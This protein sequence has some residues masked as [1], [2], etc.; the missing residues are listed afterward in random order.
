MGNRNYDPNVARSGSGWTFPEVGVF[1]GDYEL[2]ASLVDDTPPEGESSNDTIA[3]ATPTGVTA[4]NPTV[5]FNGEIFG[6]FFDPDLSLRTD[7]S[8]DVDIY[9]VELDA[10]DFLQIDIDASQIGSEVDTILRVFDAEGNGLAK[11][12]DDFAPEELFNADVGVDSYIEFTAETAGT[13][14]IGVSS[15]AN[16]PFDDFD[17]DFY[18]PNV[19]GSGSGNNFGEYEL[20]L[21]LNQPISFNGEPTVVEPPDGSGPSVSFTATPL[22]LTTDAVFL[23][24]ALVQ[25]VLDGEESPA[26]STLSVQFS[27]EGELPEDGVEI[28]L[29]T[30]AV[31]TELIDV[32]EFIAGSGVTIVGAIFDESGVPTGLRLN[33][34]ATTASFTLN[35]DN[36][37][38]VPTDGTQNLEVSLIPSAGYQADGMNFSTPIYDTLSDVPDVGTSPTV[39]LSAINT[40]LVESEGN[41]TTLTISLSEPPPAE[42]VLVFI[43]SETEDAIREFNVFDAVITGADGPFVDDDA[44]GFY[45]PMTEQTATI[46]VSAYDETTNPN[47]TVEDTLEGIETLTFSIAGGPGYNISPEANSIDI[48]IADNPD[49]VELPDDGDGGNDGGT[50]DDND[51]PENELNDTISTATDTGLNTDNPTYT[52]TATLDVQ[53][54]FSPLYLSGFTDITE[55]VDMY[56]FNLEAG[57]TITLNVEAS[58][59]TNEEGEVDVSL[60][61]PVL[62]LFDDA[63]NEVAIFE[64]SVTEDTVPQATNNASLEFTA[65]D[66]GTYYAGVSVLGNTFYDPNVEGTGSGWFFEDQFE[67]GSYLLSASLATEIQDSFIPVFG[68]LGGD[69]IEVDGGNQLVFGGAE[70]DFIDTLAGTGGNRVYGQSGDDTFVLGSGDRA[71]GGS[72]DDRFFFLGG[73]STATGGTGADQFWIAVSEIPEAANV[74]TDFTGGEDVL[75]ISGLGIG[76]D[77]LSI[78]QDNADTLIALGDDELAKLLGVTASSLSAAD[79]AFA[80]SV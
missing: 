50:G 58:D 47:L 74:V 34:F 43:D 5:T 4:D 73:E 62:R 41:T 21:A 40:E 15:F 10:G 22:T 26:T 18:D 72:G 44:S 66:A 37:E 52:T 16:S 67:P 23:A 57:Q 48:T 31:L 35:L 54:V 46:T 70:D 76:F 80:A 1:F 49:S 55:D 71:L 8:E 75:G 56:A 39:S 78:T 14:Y 9:S 64:N 33:V 24:N 29:N 36:A 7:I 68:S 61:A 3:T 53:E 25:P 17:T 77:D 20:N 12:D 79:F 13:Y 2:T 65:P 6:N 28:L 30:N 27:T 59:T 42:G 45:L 32:R 60:L 69:T 51:N 11:S 63:G 19:V 38:I